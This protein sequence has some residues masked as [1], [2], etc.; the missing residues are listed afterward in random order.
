MEEVLYIGV[1]GVPEKS[2]FYAKAVTAHRA[3]VVGQKVTLVDDIV[4]RNAA[5]QRLAYVYSGDVY[6]I[7]N[8]LNGRIIG[9]GLGKP[10][11]FE[12]NTRQRM[13]LDN[14]GFIAS[15]RKAGVYGVSEP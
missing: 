1:A 13:Y 3:M 9:D 2:A 8:L 6:S 4:T 7:N 10:G 11:N 14:L 12:G 15:Q 5:G